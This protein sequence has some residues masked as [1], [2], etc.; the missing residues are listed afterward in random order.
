MNKPLII[1]IAIAIL[2]LALGSWLYL[3]L[4]G[5]PQSPQ[6][7]FSDLGITPNAEQAVNPIQ[8]DSGTDETPA[9]LDTSG[10]RALRQLTL[11]PVAGFIALDETLRYVEQGTGHVYE[12][13][14]A[15]GQEVRISN[16]TVPTV[17]EAYFGVDG[18][19]VVVV[20]ET[21]QE[22]TVLAGS[23]ENQSLT[24]K[25]LP[26]TAE[27]IM[28]SGTSTVLYSLSTLSATNGYRYDITDTTQTQQFSIPL[29]N[30]TVSWQP[31]G[32]HAIPRVATELEGSIFA[33]LGSSMT[34]VG[35]SEF[36]LTTLFGNSWYAVSFNANNELYSRSVSSNDT[37]YE[38]P[39]VMVPEKCDWLGDALYCAAPFE[40]ESYQYLEQWYK[41]LY[42]SNDELWRVNPASESAVLIANPNTEIGRPL[43]ITRLAATTGGTLFFINRLDN[44]LWMYDA[45]IE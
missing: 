42:R 34:Q 32:V 10:E 5:A 15:N 2:L 1:T 8:A 35:S 43:D 16:T 19:H 44:T 21:P 41:G 14:L 4:F 27:N 3:F 11:R 33:V 31:Q 45:S 9:Q 7:I 37:V 22:R 25:T 6:E 38:L 23:I 24:T 13:N 39:I 28:F 20:S 40:I 29:N 36:G 12:I 30:V 17:T 26:P 18:S